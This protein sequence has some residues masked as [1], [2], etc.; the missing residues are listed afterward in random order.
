MYK[1][2]YLN[3]LQSINQKKTFFSDYKY[4]IKG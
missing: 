2:K 4:N 1:H 3:L